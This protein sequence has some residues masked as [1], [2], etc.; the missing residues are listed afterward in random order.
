VTTLSSDPKVVNAAISKALEEEPVK[1]ET[2][3][4][5]DNEV[6]LPGGY[7]SPGGILVKHAEVKELNGADEEA[8]SRAGSLGKSLSTILQRGIVSIGDE[9][10]GKDAL[11]DM[12]AA[13]R[14][15]LLLAIRRITFGDTV[16]YRAL[17]K[18]GVDTI[19]EIDLV[20][21]VPVV[22]LDNP[23]QDRT[24]TV[25]TKLG[26][27]VLSLPTGVTQKRLI[28]ATDKTTAE[29]STILLTGC[30]QSING[31]ISTG[32][33]SVLKLGMGDREKLIETIVE[34]N[35]G[36]R[37]GEVNKTCEACGESVETPL[38]LVALFRLQ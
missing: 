28:E 32:A 29:L 4:P 1:I 33:S 16:E 19:V 21:D 26:P 7:I 13:D 35:P 31:A 10:V 24:W 38:S 3:A 2:A 37:L 23:I 18:C 22:E 20:K 11:D 8:I 12:L 25:E 6:I 9:P 30:V 17:C 15:A 14:D 5:A 36:P 34:K 27:V